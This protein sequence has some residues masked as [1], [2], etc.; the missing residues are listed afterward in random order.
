MLTPD[1]EKETPMA[2]SLG[3]CVEIVHLPCGSKILY[4]NRRPA[5]VMLVDGDEWSKLV[6]EI[7]AGQHDGPQTKAPAAQ[8]RNPPMSAAQL[9]DRVLAEGSK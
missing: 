1:N 3:N 4:S 8:R 6:A 2:C 9:R 5:E 7:R